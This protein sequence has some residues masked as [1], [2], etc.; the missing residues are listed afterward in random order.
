MA[1][2]DYIPTGL[3]KN[4]VKHFEELIDSLIRFVPGLF[5][6][7]GY[8]FAVRNIEDNL[9]TKIAFL[10][11][12]IQSWKFHRGTWG[13]EISFDDY[14]NSDV[15]IDEDV[16][17]ISIKSSSTSFLCG[18][19][20]QY[21]QPALLA[22]LLITYVHSKPVLE[23][24]RD[25]V[26]LHRENLSIKDFE[27]TKTGATRCFTN[28]RKAAHQ[29]SEFGL[30]RHTQNSP[31]RTWRLSIVGFFTAL[32]LVA[33]GESNISPE[34]DSDYRRRNIYDLNLHPSIHRFFSTDVSDLSYIDHLLKL[35]I[36]NREVI[37]EPKALKAISD[38]RIM[39]KVHLTSRNL[40]DSEKKE[41][42]GDLVRELENELAACDYMGKLEA[43][44]EVDKI[45]AHLDISKS[46]Y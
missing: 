28:I 40:K 24:I 11:G 38:T 22:Y 5:N 9:E 43:C 18:I 25:F 14:L 34:K 3:R 44:I 4:E 42:F 15:F 10:E 35:G 23:V 29:L 37:Q 46:P 17:R 1:Y 41:K 30:L 16:I 27:R 36:I 33:S 2:P 32:Y 21:Y 6:N 26:D 8:F 31:M 7:Y 12:M 45:T 39:C 19:P 20:S 13:R